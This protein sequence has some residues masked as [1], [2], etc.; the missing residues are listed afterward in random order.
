[1]VPMDLEWGKDGRTGELY[2]LQARPETVHSQNGSPQLELFR[3]RGKGRLLAHGKSV[4]SRVA[5]GPARVIH[6]AED[7]ATFREGEVLVAP[8]TDP[9]WEPVMKR[10]RA[11]VT[12]H[13]GRTCHA[14]I[15]SRELG[16]PCVV[17]SGN[18]SATLVNGQE[19]TVSC[20]EG[21]D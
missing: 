3:M 18:A 19:V 20:A 17:G 7:L 15:V 8:M 9:D 21:D 16:L 10:A 14:A 13:G 11:I 12:D 5:A 4:G 6:A 2:I 1:P